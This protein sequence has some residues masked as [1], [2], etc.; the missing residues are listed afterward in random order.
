LA[1]ANPCSKEKTIGSG[2]FIKHASRYR[3]RNMG[4]GEVTMYKDDY[5]NFTPTSHCS[6][7]I[8]KAIDITG[9]H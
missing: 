6:N 3:Y 9:Q 1:K 7:D 2:I 5:P 4:F 8:V